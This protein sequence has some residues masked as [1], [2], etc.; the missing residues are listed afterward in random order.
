MQIHAILGGKERGKGEKEG[1]EGRERG[2]R[3]ERE[4]KGM[5]GKE[6]RKRGRRRERRRE[7]R[8]FGKGKN[9]NERQLAAKQKTSY[10]N[11]TPT[12]HWFCALCST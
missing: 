5:R 3:R 1:R 6:E 11:F 9:V 10:S 7:G 2:E 4:E 8:S 12:A